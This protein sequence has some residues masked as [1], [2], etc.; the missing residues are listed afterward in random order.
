MLLLLSILPKGS[1][2]GPGTYRHKTCTDELLNKVTSLK[3]PYKLYS[4]DR[5]KPISE[6]YLAAPV[7]RTYIINI[8]IYIYIYIWEENGRGILL[9]FN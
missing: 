8:Y 3:G 5:N 6:G 2:L 4:G 1:H 7:S 9:F